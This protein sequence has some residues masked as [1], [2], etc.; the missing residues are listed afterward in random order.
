MEKGLLRDRY[1]VGDRRAC[2]RP[3]EEWLH[4]GMCGTA[5]WER[6]STFLRHRTTRMKLIDVLNGTP[7][8]MAMRLQF[9]DKGQAV[10]AKE[11]KNYA[12]NNWRAV[13]DKQLDCGNPPQPFVLQVYPAS[14]C[15]V[16]YPIK[17]LAC[18]SDKIRIQP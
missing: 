4:R 18:A 10:L 3:G 13:I 5:R 9:E 14:K 12:I 6:T 15:M 11:A 1:C 17:C 7:L 2:R 16:L 8:G